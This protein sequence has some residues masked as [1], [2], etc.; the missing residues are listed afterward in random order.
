MGRPWLYGAVI[1][2]Q[3]GIEQVI[4]H[5]LADFDNTLGLAGYQSV[6]ELRGSAAESLQKVDF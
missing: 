2:G 1:A 5:T 4:T 6:E 3:A